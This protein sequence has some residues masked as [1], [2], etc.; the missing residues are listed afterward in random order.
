MEQT[1]QQAIIFVPDQGGTSCG[2]PYWLSPLRRPS[3]AAFWRFPRADIGNGSCRTRG[4]GTEFRQCA[5]DRPVG[6]FQISERG[7]AWACSPFHAMPVLASI[8][9]TNV[10]NPTLGSRRVIVPLGTH[11]L[12]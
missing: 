10:E 7:S 9:G 3:V 11:T 2:F 1:W 5:A 8:L 4:R 6:P 12:D